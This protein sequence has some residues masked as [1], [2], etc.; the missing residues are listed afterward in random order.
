VD[1][2]VFVA[3]EAAEAKVRQLARERGLLVGWST[4]AAL[5]AAEAVLARATAQRGRPPVVVA[6]APDGGA[7]YLADERRL[8]GEP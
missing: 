4:G 5:V 7:G 3:T 1:E 8:L 6:I 2:T